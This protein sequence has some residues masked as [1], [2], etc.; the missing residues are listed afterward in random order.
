MKKRVL[1]ANDGEIPAGRVK[2]FHYGHW[3]GIAYND[4]G[5]IKA[6]RNVCTHAGAPVRLCQKGTLQCELHEAEFDPKT[7]DRLCGEAPEGSRLTPIEIIHENEM[8]YAVFEILDEFD[9]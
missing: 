3:K 5:E 8:I 6:Y 7:G 9:I 1:I 4:D 2:S